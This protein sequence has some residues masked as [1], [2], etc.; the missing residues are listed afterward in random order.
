MIDFT[1]NIDSL[2][3]MVWN[4]ILNPDNESTELRPKNHASLSREELIG[5]I[6]PKYFNGENR[7][8]SFKYALKFYRLTADL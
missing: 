6:A 7:Q 3:T 2:E 5:L 8:E 1:E 4:F